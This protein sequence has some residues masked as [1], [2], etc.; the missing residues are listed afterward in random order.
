M[1]RTLAKGWRSRNW[2]GTVQSRQEEEIF[3]ELAKVGLPHAMKVLTKEGATCCFH[4]IQSPAGSV[5]VPLD[6][7]FTSKYTK[8]LL[9]V[10][11]R[12]EGERV[13]VSCIIVSSTEF[14]GKGGRQT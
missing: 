1:W 6:Y 8:A 9:F 7:I 5:S 13:W 4:G 14:S 12:G 2:V 3:E 11:W 10:F